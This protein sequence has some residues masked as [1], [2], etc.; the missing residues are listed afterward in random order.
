MAEALAIR[1]ALAHLRAPSL[2]AA[3]ASVRMA[4]AP[5]AHYYELRVRA[6]ERAA[7][8]AVEHALGVALP[9]CNTTRRFGAGTLAWLAPDQWLIDLGHGAGDTGLAALRD[10]ADEHFI[11]LTDVSDSYCGLDLH[12]ARAEDVLRKGC[13]LDLHPALFAPGQCA[14]TLLAKARVLLW[15]YVEGRERAF[16]V[17][18]D[19]SYADYL[20]RWLC[21]AMLEY[22]PG[23]STPAAPP[24]IYDGTAD[25]SRRPA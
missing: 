4:V 14:R 13:P 9:V 10:L 7:I 8:E 12:G 16:R 21:D 18:V 22:M 25:L 17:M 15:P 6:D 11:V 24:S 19:R 5:S 20:W 2:A 1:G 3:E 23:I